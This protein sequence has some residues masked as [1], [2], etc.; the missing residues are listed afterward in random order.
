MKLRMDGSETSFEESCER[1]PFAPLI[2]IAVVVA[3]ATA[4]RTAR[5]NGRSEPANAEGPAGALRKA[6]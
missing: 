4:M 5:P 6:R 2:R 1:A 3:E